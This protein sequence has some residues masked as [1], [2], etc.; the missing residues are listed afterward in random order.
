MTR[1]VFSG[2]FDVEMRSLHWDNCVR[3]SKINDPV[4]GMGRP[5]PGH[6]QTGSKV[7][8]TPQGVDLSDKMANRV[9]K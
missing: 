1:V 4:S 6:A 2:K 9:R 7:V 3:P 5:L 8:L